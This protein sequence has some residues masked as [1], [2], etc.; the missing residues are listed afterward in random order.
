M[1]ATLT[2]APR[3]VNLSKDVIHVEIE[4]DLF[5]GTEAPFIPNEANLSLYVQVYQEQNDGEEFLSEL[6]VP[7]SVQNKKGFFDLSTVLDVANRA[8]DP[9][10]L[11]VVGASS[12]FVDHEAAAKF[13]FKFANKFGSPATV[14]ST[15]ENSG[16]YYAIS[17]SSLY[18]Q[19]P[20]QSESIMLHSY[21]TRDG[22]VI[23]KE[24]TKSEP[25]FYYF[26][27][28]TSESV[29]LQIVFHYSDG[30]AGHDIR[31][32]TSEAKKVNYIPIGYAQ[33][34][35]DLLIDPAR[36]LLYYRVRVVNGLS[37]FGDRLFYLDDRDPD[38]KR[39]L[40][41]SN[42]CGGIDVVRLSGYGIKKINVE[43]TQYTR[44]RTANTSFQD[45]NIG[46]ISQSGFET[47]EA[48]TGYYSEEYINHLAQVA[49]GDAW[50]IDTNRNQ[51]YKVAILNTEIEVYNE[52]EDKYSMV[53]NI[54]SNDIQSP[55]N[56]NL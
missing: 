19:G 1:P 50:I 29:T 4:G 38:Q 6:N 2:Q 36:E 47:I 8:P 15:L 37:F 18:M 32:F 33:L 44:P 17:G 55:N 3:D 14:E 46:H 27:A 23:F 9:N 7:Y 12:L 42:G 28:D 43:K 31:T 53:F 51:F 13:Y 25:D 10:A 30:I 26:W 49:F 56:F 24:V 21:Y 16:D 20:P 5:T 52:Q 45:G 11:N 54:R 40:A 39:Y 48:S 41:Y 22:Q 34:K 35:A